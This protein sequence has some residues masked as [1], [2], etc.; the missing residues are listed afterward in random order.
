MTTT[1]SPETTST[2]SIPVLSL[3]SDGNT[4]KYLTIFKSKAVMSVLKGASAT[5]IVEMTEIIQEIFSRNT[6]FDETLTPFS[7]SLAPSGANAAVKKTIVLRGMVAHALL[8]YFCD[9]LIHNG[10][11]TQAEEYQMEF[12]GR[13]DQ[14]YYSYLELIDADKMTGAEAQAL[15]N[16]WALLSIDN[17]EDQV[18]YLKALNLDYKSELE[19]LL[20][21][22]QKA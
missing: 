2:S 9:V 3:E 17:H 8:N 19:Q 12:P 20:S 22:S 4:K 5:N 1:S 10:Y 18:D 14:A 7:L 16:K 6:P 11:R 21:T 15:E 13:G